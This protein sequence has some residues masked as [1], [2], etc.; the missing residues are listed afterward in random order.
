MIY[1]DGS[2]DYVSNVTPA[3]GE[4]VTVR[5]RTAAGAP[6]RRVILRTLYDGEQV[7][8][9]MRR[10]EA[11]PWALWESEIAVTE[12]RIGYRFLVLTD[13][14]QGFYNTQGLCE[15]EPLDLFD[16][17]IL[18]GYQAPEWVKGA[19]FYQ[20][21]P[22]TWRNERPELGPREDDY[23]LHGHR[24]CLKRWG[25]P[26]QPG[27]PYA[28]SYYGGDLYGVAAGLGHV[29]DLGA[30]AIYLNPVFKAFSTHRYDTVDYLQVDP[31]L[32][33][34][35]ALAALSE[36]LRAR[37]MRAV[38]DV[39][40]NHCGSRHPWFLQALAD[41]DAPERGFF[42]F[43]RYPDEYDCWGGYKNLVKL[44]YADHE[45]R[46]RMYGGRDSVLR[47]W[48]RPP[49]LIDGWRVDV[50]NM[51]GRAGMVQVNHEVLREMR[52]AVKAE[53]PDSYLMGENFMDATDQLQ[54]DMWD[55]VMNYCGFY[56]PIVDWLVGFQREV[57]GFPEAVTGP[58][59]LSTAALVQ[60]W[61]ERLG[62]VPWAVNL[63]QF[64]MLGSHDTERVTTTLGD[65]EQL[66]WLA[67]GYQMTFPGVPCIYYGNE[68]GMRN[69]TGEA[70]A[71]AGART[72]M[73]WDRSRWDTRAYRR[74][75]EL[76]RLRRTRPALIE[77]GFQVLKAGQDGFIYQRKRGEDGVLFTANRS[78]EP[79]H[80]GAV[81][82]AAA[83]WR[84]GTLFRE[85]GGQRTACVVDDQLEFPPLEQGGLIWLTE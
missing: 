56:T 75:Q 43:T 26:L 84:P 21:N 11:G 53:R 8:I 41:P 24:P 3:V 9:E 63:Q 71:R 44:N 19:V 64:N 48:L 80:A 27:E 25:E 50:G 55:G 57:L 23:E 15:H 60:T 78:P 22:D 2:A 65:K 17:K 7:F 12:P 83:G 45:L 30:N 38:L 82:A 69:P 39:V 70:A 72:C 67:V 54:G 52:Q 40:P 34:N 49:Y 66:Y 61:I 4:T 32:G 13:E 73:E 76:I 79:W 29:Q 58:A 47:F 62:A 59:A 31:A 33:G 14:G 74:Y 18:G 77:G 35:E 16:F 42:V 28:H 10:W 6:V 68:I 1:H 5:L 37:G 36:A 51:L 20:I 46:R 85:M 81:D